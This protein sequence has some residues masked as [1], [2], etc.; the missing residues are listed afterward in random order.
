M[1][2]YFLFG[3]TGTGKTYIAD[4]LHHEFNIEHINGDAF[5]TPRMKECLA[6]GVQMTSDMIDE[7]V[8]SLIKIITNKKQDM[9]GESFIVS[10]ALYLDKNRLAVLKAFPKELKFVLIES[11]DRQ[12]RNRIESRFSALKSKVSSEYALDMDKFFQQPTHPFI[13]VNND[14]QDGQLLVQH[15]RSSLPDLSFE[16]AQQYEM[17]CSMM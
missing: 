13:T 14:S 9:D 12:R 6:K 3:K 16:S 4:L 7:F 1:T 5:I 8:L 2:I 11:N 15:L 17:S 10:Q